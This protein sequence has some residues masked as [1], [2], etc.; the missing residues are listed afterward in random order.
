M[1]EEISFLHLGMNFMT[2]LKMAAG[3]R[4]LRSANPIAHKAYPKPNLT[5]AHLEKC[6]NLDNRTS[7]LHKISKAGVVAEFGVNK[8]DFS[9]KILDIVQPQKLHLVDIWSS[10]RYHTGLK[11]QV[12][13]KFSKEIES[14]QVELNLGMS[15]N[16]IPNYPDN[17]FDFVYI[18]TDHELYNTQKE[19]ALI[20]PKMKVNGVIAGHDYIIGNWDGVVR[21]GVMEAVNSF[22]LQH[23]WALSYLTHEMDDNPSFAITKMSH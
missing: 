19:L 13:A 3:K 23:D 22:C 21:Y 14:G 1:I 8:G 18:D 15:T 4:L 9:A 12:E 20:L 17:Y 6:Q 5:A 11:A 2:R 16:V 7:L 10:K